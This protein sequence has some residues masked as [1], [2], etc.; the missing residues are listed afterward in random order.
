M[1]D[2]LSSGLQVRWRA[3][4]NCGVRRLAAQPDM[5]VLHYTAMNT[6]QAAEDRLCDP[7][8]EVSAHYLIGRDGQI[9]Q[10][11]DE[12]ARAWHAGAGRWGSVTDVNSRSIGIELDNDG[13]S[14]FAES[15]MVA[16]MALMPGIMRRW[17]IR[18]WRVIGHSDM[19]PGRK[20]DPGPMFDWHRLARA[21]QA[22]WPQV[23]APDKAD[24]EKFR[25]G[26]TAFGYSPDLDDIALISAFRLRFAPTNDGPL[27]ARETAAALDLGRRFPVDRAEQPA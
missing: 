4:P 20:I 22:V 2:K 1:S 11:V 21:R 18:P 6:A 7:D 12:R 10:L 25:A 9:T 17:R 5:I 8:F 3:S 19:A 26:A 16:L 27:T 14:E 15:Q 23:G 13:Q 24:V